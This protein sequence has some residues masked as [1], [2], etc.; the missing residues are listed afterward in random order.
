MYP[1]F[2]N[3]RPKDTQNFRFGESMALVVVDSRRVDVVDV[4]YIPKVKEEVNTGLLNLKE[5]TLE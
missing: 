2:W 3:E 4:K 1:G 5:K